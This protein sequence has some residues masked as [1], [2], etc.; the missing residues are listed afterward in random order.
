MSITE[1]CFRAD[2]FDLVICSH[3]LEHV[4]ADRQAMGELFRVVRPGGV[5]IV[6]VPISWNSDMT[7]EE[8]G[9]TSL[10]KRERFGE[11]DHVRRYG[12]DYLQRLREA[13]FEVELHRLNDAQ[14][15]SRYRI[16]NRDP[17]VVARKPSH[18]DDTLRSLA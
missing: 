2:A 7:D 10:E 12:R 18:F 8:E 13:G 11:E 15:G 3:V 5:A 16:D 6:P 4:K 17:L 14:L 1:I 9:L